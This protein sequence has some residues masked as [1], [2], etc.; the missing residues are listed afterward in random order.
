MKPQS[1]STQEVSNAFWVSTKT[2]NVWVELRE[3]RTSTRKLTH[4]RPIGN[5]LDPDRVGKR[6]EV[7]LG[8]YQETRATM[9]RFHIVDC[10]PREDEEEV[11]KGRKNRTLNKENNNKSMNGMV[12]VEMEVS[13]IGISSP[14]GNVHQLLQKLD[15]INFTNP[16]VGS[17]K[18]ASAHCTCK[19]ADTLLRT[20]KPSSPPREF[21]GRSH[22]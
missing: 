2:T 16:C 1:P 19:L 22:E 7:Q 17:I 11:K 20:K 5:H 4:P 13:H 9:Q 18:I 14:S 8:E 15:A 10:T 21:S 12:K 3:E 6:C